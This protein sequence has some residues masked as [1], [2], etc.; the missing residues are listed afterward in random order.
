MPKYLK[1]IIFAGLFLVPFVPLL[2]SGSLFFPFITT[3]AFT[4]RIIVEIIFAAWLLL[5][6][7]DVNY[8]PKKSFILYSI[9]LL[10]VVIGLSNIF[11]VAPLKSLWSNF[12][13][14]E[15][16]LALVHLGMFFLVISTVFREADWKAWWNTSLVATFIMVLYC[17]FQ[18]LGIKTI[19][20]GGVRVDG[21][22]GNAIY[23]AVYMLFHMFIAGLFLWRNWQNIALR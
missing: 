19:N 15:G 13:R 18:L 12:E 7:L 11:G 22:L 21:T 4:W 17:A 20:Q 6:L 2:V 23:L 16:Y 5:A 10:L 9:A 14:M 1:N 3:K 8:R